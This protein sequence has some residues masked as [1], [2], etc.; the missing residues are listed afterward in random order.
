MKKLSKIITVVG[1][2]A[3]GKSGLAIEL[4]RKFNGEIISCD[5]RQIYRGMDIGTA[6]E[7]DFQGITHHLLDV[8][9]PD[10]RYTLVDFQNDANRVIARIINKGKLPVLVGG[11]GLYVSAVTEN[12]DVDQK[13]KKDLLYDVLE[14]AIEVDR[15][16]L[17]ERIDQRVDQMMDEG[18]VEEVKTVG[19]KFGYDNVAMTG[20]GYRQICDYLKGET[21]LSLAVEQIKKDTRHY[22]KRQLTW[23]RHHGDVKWIK[24]KT[25]AF[26]QVEKFLNNSKNSGLENFI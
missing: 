7:K 14:L 12:W 9:D 16:Q 24:N 23:W 5:S 18:L 10:Q 3:S 26:K 1:P 17:Y 6:K 2:T 22:A 15:K 4:S 21:T 25:Q 19:E 8:V 13:T 11:T 20:I